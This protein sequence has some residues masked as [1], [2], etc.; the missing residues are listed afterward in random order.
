MR[1]VAGG[2]GLPPLRVP[3]DRGTGAANNALEVTTLGVSMSNEGTIILGIEKSSFSV[4]RDSPAR[5]VPS[6]RLPGIPK[7]MDGLQR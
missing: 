2:V 5:E 4:V 1:V 3:T 6:E 7:S